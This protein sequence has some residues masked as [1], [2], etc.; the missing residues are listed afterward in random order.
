M[1]ATLKPTAK[2]V[3]DYQPAIHEDIFLRVKVDNG[4]A[5]FFY[6]L[7]GKKFKPAGDEFIMREG[8]WIGAKIGL[9]AAQPCGN[10]NRGWIDA[11]WF[12]VTPF[13]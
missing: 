3:V 13:N 12:R 11:D 7:D 5:N 2:D 8:K 4:K 9:V 10:E 6:S 1:L